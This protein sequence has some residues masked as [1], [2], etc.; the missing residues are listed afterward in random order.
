MSKHN[1]AQDV[2]IDPKAGRAE[3]QRVSRIVVKE[4]L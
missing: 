4:N 2:A 3:Y 1:Q